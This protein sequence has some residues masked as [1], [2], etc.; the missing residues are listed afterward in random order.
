MTDQEDNYS[1]YN[2]IISIGK[3]ISSFFSSLAI[4][5]ASFAIIACLIALID[6]D[7]IVVVQGNEV[8]ISLIFILVVI[9]LSFL[10]L[11]LACF[12]LYLLREVS[13]D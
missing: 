6:A 11:F 10:F 2:Y 3:T 1:N 5:I 4:A 12:I 13:N 9:F 8:S 7:G